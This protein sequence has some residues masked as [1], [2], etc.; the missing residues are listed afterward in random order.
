M[1]TLPFPSPPLPYTLRSRERRLE[2]I[3]DA[4]RVRPG[5]GGDIFR[6]LRLEPATNGV[7]YFDAAKA[8]TRRA[9]IFHAWR[10]PALERVARNKARFFLRLALGERA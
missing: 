7:R 8:A 3:R 5:N 2:T 4:M 6:R 1:Q 9:Q 10:M